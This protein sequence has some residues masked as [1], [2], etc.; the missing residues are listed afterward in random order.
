MNIQKIKIPQIKLYWSEWITWYK[1]KV[2]ARSN[3]EGVTPPNKPGVYE[4]RHSYQKECLT[5]GATNNLR[6]RI[7]QGLVKGKVPHSSGKE[8]R[9]K[10]NTKT[11]VV[12]WAETDR[13]FATEEDL[14]KKY[15]KRFDSLP[16]H[17]KRT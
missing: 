1:L 7:K 14:H 11:I 9:R 3:R 6:Y 16:K 15:K 13:P 2:D 12:R 5:I 10:E 8:I 4:A 17:T